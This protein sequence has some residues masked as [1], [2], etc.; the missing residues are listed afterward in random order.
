MTRPADRTHAAA[1]PL[2]AD[3]TPAAASPRSAAS[4]RRFLQGSA[5]AMA[6]AAGTAAI[7]E[8]SA[9]AAPAGPT[10]PAPVGPSPSASTLPDEDGHELW[11]RYRRPRSEDRAKEYSTALTST[12]VVGKGAILDNAEG[13]LHRALKAITGSAPKSVKPEKASI[14]L[15]H[16]EGTGAK[17]T[18]GTGGASAQEVTETVTALKEDADPLLR[19]AGAEG[20]A[21]L[22][23]SLDDDTTQYV[24]VSTTQRG[25]LYGAFALL[26]TLQL[27]KPLRGL[28]VV[29]TPKIPMRMLN[30]WDNWD[31][32]IERGYAGNSIFAWDQLPDV[33]DRVVDYARAMSSI[34]INA[35]VVN[36]VNTKPDFLTPE[37][38]KN[39]EPL[40]STLA[41]WGIDMWMSVNYASPMLLTADD[42]DPIDT[43]DPFDER[44]QKFWVDKATE[45]V[46]HLDGF[47]GVLVKA[48]S[49]GQAGPLDYG[50]TH[51]DGANMLARAFAPH[52]CT[53]IWRSFVHE[54]FGDWSEFQDRIFAPLDG[55]FDENVIV[56][57]KNGPIDFQVREP[58]HPL[59]ATMKNTN[60]ML[61]LQVSQEYTGQSTHTCY[62][63]PQWSEVLG[64]TT[65]GP[66]A[67]PTVA[68]IVTTGPL[69]ADR[70]GVCAVSNIGD[71][72][73][74][75]GYQLGAA[76]A[77]AFGRICWDPDVKPRKLAQEWVGMTFGSDEDVTSTVVDILL[78]SRAT[79]EHYTGP[80][81]MGYLTHP[82][83]DHFG[84]DLVSTLFQS[85]HSTSKGTGFDRTSATGT[86]FTG[87]YPKGWAKLYESVEDCPEELLLFMH[88]LPYDHRLSSG[89][90]IIQHIYDSHF[91]G[92]EEAAGFRD[93]WAGLEGLVDDARHQ[94]IADT[95]DE[96]VAQAEIWRDAVVDFFF[97]TSLVADEQREWL[98][99]AP[100]SPAVVLAGQENLLPVELHHASTK[101][102][103]VKLEMSAPGKGWD[104]KTGTVKVKGPE[105]TSVDLPVTPPVKADATTGEFTLGVDPDLQR[106]SASDGRIVVAPSGQ[107]CLLALNAGTADGVGAP[108]YTALT[109]DSAWSK[110]AGFGWVGKE[111]LARDRTGQ[112]LVRDFA[113]NDESRTLRLAV[114]KGKHTARMLIGDTGAAATAT[115]VSIGGK[116]IAKSEKQSAGV[117]TWLELPL[118]GGADGKNVDLTFTGDGG[119]WRLGSLV[120]PDPDAKAPT[121]YS[122]N[123]ESEAVWFLD[124][125]NDVTVTVRNTSKKARQVTLAAK[126]PKGWKVTEA[127]ARVA[128]RSDAELTVSVTPSGD[129]GNGSVELQLHEGKKV[130]ESG[131]TVAAVLVPHGKDVPLALDAG[132]KDVAVLDSYD[133]L[134]P[135]SMYEKGGDFGWSGDAPGCRDRGNDDDLR[136]DYVTGKGDPAHLKLKVPEGKHTLWLLTGDSTTDVG[137]TIVSENGKELVRSNDEVLPSRSFVWFSTT[138]DGGVGG[139]VAD[140]ALS[141]KEEYNGGLWRINAVILA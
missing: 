62:L 91:A 124:R 140:L 36:N 78:H 66:D 48:N 102:R 88:Q 44:V 100:P 43:A 106:L 32:S 59:F 26:R 13:E 132:P 38:L 80:L 2:P 108:G 17:A 87:L 21:L 131:R 138:L 50:R 54:D 96:H 29:D 20:Y 93:D 65:E 85:H 101:S 16:M 134:G 84:P 117:F 107:R 1:H 8:Q 114:P 103:N 135:D 57:T 72:T 18:K 75:T 125:K 41:S 116:E 5:L 51:A 11:L 128:A 120:I 83:G 69:D 34:G 64:F 19:K 130:V 76:N 55:D 118:D 71:D 3:R 15:A 58:V 27:E 33:P 82:G 74:W 10:G 81:G 22:E 79:Y 98:R 46:D 40:A 73:D 99:V 9:F 110:K 104:M 77:H 112:V 49:E 123:A 89:S 141:G 30:H 95:F 136:R 37:M 63:A 53:V 119:P 133:R 67:G 45:I 111:P 92:A 25:V 121:L 60:Q 52:D 127:S 97:R 115:S 4:R 68:D 109:P 126:A 23:R 137:T 129:P 90:T 14:L 28:S 42:K 122:Q 35:A 39:L 139:R 12:A 7:S 6:A 47:G 86:G 31:G 56:Q 61:E 113:Y 70:T 94:A 105:V 24:V